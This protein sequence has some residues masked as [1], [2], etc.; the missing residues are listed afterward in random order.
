MKKRKYR[1]RS[2]LPKKRSIEQILNDFGMSKDAVVAAA[3][4]SRVQGI[5]QKVDETLGSK[6]LRGGC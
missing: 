2:E 3:R 4:D 5:L 1:R 6:S